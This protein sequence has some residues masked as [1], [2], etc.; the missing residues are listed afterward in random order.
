[1]IKRFIRPAALCTLLLTISLPGQAATTGGYLAVHHEQRDGSRASGISFT[2]YNKGFGLGVS[3]NKITSS[4][5]LEIDNR[6]TLYPVYAFA[7]LSLPATLS[8]Y[9]EIGIDLG[10]YLMYEIG[11]DSE[12]T[13]NAN[14][15]QS[16]D[17][18]DIYGAVGI[19]T[20]M[21]RAP[22][23][24]SLYLKSYA[25]VFNNSNINQY[26]EQLREGSVITMGGANIIVNF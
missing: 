6:D 20:S 8:P 24:F 4:K 5:P 25:I 15:E 23:D 7:K 14:I 11:K 18:I 22:I 10:D 12:A 16:S 3:A 19:K 26:G 1:M 13:T 9:V 21:R 17:P 2:A